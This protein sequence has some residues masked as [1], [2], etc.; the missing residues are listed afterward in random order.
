M[1]ANG[2]AVSGQ[3]VIL[4]I[5]FGRESARADY[6]TYWQDSPLNSEQEGRL[7]WLVSGFG[8]GALTDLMRLCVK[9]FRHVDFVES[10][11]QDRDLAGAL[12]SL[13]EKPSG[14]AEETFQRMYPRVKRQAVSDHPENRYAGGS[15]RSS[16]LPGE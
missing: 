2:N 12:K 13:L 14:S 15:K 10:F 1:V 6:Q 3:I 16:E 4:A 5:G 8:D 7:K 9:H 11:A